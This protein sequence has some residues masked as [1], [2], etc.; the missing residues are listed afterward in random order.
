M[1]IPTLRIVNPI[2]SQNSPFVIWCV[3]LFAGL[4]LALQVFSTQAPARLEVP[5]PSVDTASAVI[6]GETARVTLP[7]RTLTVT[8]G[9]TSRADTVATI[10]GKDYSIQREPEGRLKVFLAL[11]LSTIMAG[12][13]W[14]KKHKKKLLAIGLTVVSPVAGAATIATAAL[15][16]I[17]PSLVSFLLFIVIPSLLWFKNRIVNENEFKV[18]YLDQGYPA[19]IVNAVIEFSR[20]KPDG[21][22]K[23]ILD[24]LKGFDD[25]GVVKKALETLGET[26]RDDYKSKGRYLISAA[27]WAARNGKDLEAVPGGLNNYIERLSQ[28]KPKDSRD[29]W[30]KDTAKLIGENKGNLSRVGVA[31][32]DMNLISSLNDAYKTMGGLE[33]PEILSGDLLLQPNNL[34]VP[35]PFREFWNTLALIV[36]QEGGYLYA[37][38]GGDEFRVPMVGENISQRYERIVSRYNQMLAERYDFHTITASQK[39]EDSLKSS[40][41]QSGIPLWLV[42]HGKGYVVMVDRQF[43]GDNYDQSLRKIIKENKEWQIEQ[44]SVS[45]TG[46]G[47]T[48]NSLGGFEFD[49]LLSLLKKRL[50]VDWLA[51][52]LAMARV[53]D[54]LANDSLAAA[55]NLSRNLFRMVQTTSELESNSQNNSLSDKNLKKIYE[56]PGVYES[57][58]APWL[59]PYQRFRELVNGQKGTMVFGD[60]T[61]YYKEKVGKYWWSRLGLALM[62]RMLTLVEKYPSVARFVPLHWFRQA[63]VRAVVRAFH[64]LKGS[65]DALGDAVR[66]AYRKVMLEWMFGEEV[67][68]LSNFTPP[69]GV[70]ITNFGPDNLLFFIPENASMPQ[71]DE[72][73]FKEL[74]RKFR[75]ALGS[76]SGMKN[77]MKLLKG[78]LDPHL[79]ILTVPTE[80]IETGSKAGDKSPDKRHQELGELIDLE[81][82]FVSSSRMVGSSG[83]NIGN[84]K[85]VVDADLFEEA[86]VLLLKYSK[87]TEKLSAFEIKKREM[88]EAKGTKA[89]GVLR[90]R[91][92]PY[93]PSALWNGFTRF[94]GKYFGEKA[95]QWAKRTMSGG[96]LF[97]SVVVPF[98]E[99]VIFPGFILFN[100]LGLSLG[101]LIPFAALLAALTHGIPYLGRGPPKKWYQQSIDQFVVRLCAS[102]ALFTFAAFVGTW[103]FDLST[104]DW[105]NTALSAYTFHAIYNFF[106]PEQYRLSL[107]NGQSIDEFAETVKDDVQTWSEVKEKYAAWLKENHGQEKADLFLHILNDLRFEVN[108]DHGRWRP[109]QPELYMKA[110]VQALRVPPSVTGRNGKHVPSK[111]TTKKESPLEID[112]VTMEALFYYTRSSLEKMLEEK[113]NAFNR[114]AGQFWELSEL[115]KK[116]VLRGAIGFSTIAARVMWGKISTDVAMELYKPEEYYDTAK[117][118]QERLGLDESGRQELANRTNDSIRYSIYFFFPNIETR[119]KGVYSLVNKTLR[120]RIKKPEY[121]INDIQDLFTTKI[122]LPN[123]SGNFKEWKE[124]VQACLMKITGELGTSYPEE[125][126]LDHREEYWGGATY[127]TLIVP[128]TDQ[129]GNQKYDASGK[130][131]TF[132]LELQFFSETRYALL[133]LGAGKDGYKSKP[134]WMYKGNDFIRNVFTERKTALFTSD[135]FEKT[136]DWT[137]NIFNLANEWGPNNVVGVIGP[138]DQ[139]TYVELPVGVKQATFIDLAGA[140]GQIGWRENDETCIVGGPEIVGF[141]KGLLDTVPSGAIVKFKRDRHFFY[142]RERL[143]LIGNAGLD[144]TKVLL[145]RPKERITKSNAT[146]VKLDALITGLGKTLQSSQKPG[147]AGSVKLD[148]K[149]V[150]AK[151]KGMLTDRALA[152]RMSES[153]LLVLLSEKPELLFSEPPESGGAKNA[154]ELFKKQRALL[155]AYLNVSL[156]TMNQEGDGRFIY[157]LTEMGAVSDE[158]LNQYTED[159]NN[160]RMDQEGG[161]ALSSRNLPKNHHEVTINTDDRPGLLLL[162]MN[163]LVGARAKLISASTRSVN[164]T[165]LIYTGNE[166]AH[167][168]ALIAFGKIPKIKKG[169]QTKGTQNINV[170][171]NV[172]FKDIPGNNNELDLTNL[173]LQFSRFILGHSGNIEKIEIDSKPGERKFWL[174]VGI[175]KNNLLQI[176]T[177][178]QQSSP[179]HEVQQAIDQVNGELSVVLPQSGSGSE[180]GGSVGSWV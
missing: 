115:E 93:F 120:E 27:L 167:N 117:A 39:D 53:A 90:S 55:K 109:D 60:V 89:L 128:L 149:S 168:K 68:D 174:K 80:A 159:L 33:R 83:A 135:S 143:N 70:L 104:L 1:N 106:A 169:K 113:K 72:A 105:K 134:Y 8:E 54:W 10:S 21:V 64:K 162:Y 98:V 110:V 108:G 3:N 130:P 151:V 81:G 125:K 137:E 99:L 139:M 107:V 92:Q 154:T 91:V 101:V 119:A 23:E 6:E 24:V 56:N 40:L 102:L 76:I 13:T 66:D 46:L 4:V 152:L 103:G 176:E 5:L 86:N 84:M 47:P 112:L 7:Q 175:S 156:E 38:A 138:G 43:A 11:G 94:V 144:R 45:R 140:A 42:R 153:E 131:L 18:R 180:M 165:T 37:G 136:S 161:S 29:Q 123:R 69:D 88:E 179:W 97:Y 32:G 145:L 177:T 114:D 85:T 51:K 173:T 36:A 30:A 26:K 126:D 50:D 164:Q 132:H 15:Y 157:R 100:P 22:D 74:T 75:E 52:P 163:I 146:Q 12:L 87:N 67:R 95:G 116:E 35:P 147:G 19:E 150:R 111:S 160:Y 122:I 96:A 170:E 41:E 48:S 20:F 49:K 25:V 78:T 148:E 63:E 58:S 44:R 62:D 172:T 142:D 118:Y 166:N 73:T 34:A 28:G 61:R 129:E 79:S 16:P 9:R 171:F 178:P 77:T 127:T 133:N 59:L 31:N 124:H 71:F 155:A 14:A 2:N 158:D 57:Q 65:D 82:F 121:G 17:F 141:E